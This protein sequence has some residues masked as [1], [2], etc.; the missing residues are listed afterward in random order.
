[1]S[2]DAAALR[3]A[4]GDLLEGRIGLVRTLDEG[5]FAPGVFK[6]Q[7][8]E[9]QKSLAVQTQTARHRYDVELGGMRNHIATGVATLGPR[10]IAEVGVTVRVTTAVVT[11]NQ[12]AQRDTDI[13]EILQDC[14][15]A[16]W[17]LAYPGCLAETFEGDATGLIDGGSLLGPGDASVADVQI[18]NEDWQ[19]QLIT[20][21]IRGRVIVDLSA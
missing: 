12:R 10:R 16:A 9:T 7:P 6:G 21:E 20:T 14:S 3:C 15:D 19:R 17:A 2:W 1:V 18:V 4:I 8:E 5:R 11:P 13:G